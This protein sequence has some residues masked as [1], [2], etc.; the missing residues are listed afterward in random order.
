MIYRAADLH[1]ATLAPWSRSHS[2]NLSLSSPRSGS[3]VNRQSRRWGPP[4]L[5]SLFAPSLLILS[6]DEDWQQGLTFVNENGPN[7]IQMFPTTCNLQG[8]SEK[9]P[10][11]SRKLQDE[12]VLV[13]RGLG[14]SLQWLLPKLE[15]AQEA[16][17]TVDKCSL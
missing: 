6:V 2:G 9:R 13:D 1:R 10:H 4:S 14:R 11:T 12:A 16:T 7:I 17:G 8:S 15:C 5:S 3:R